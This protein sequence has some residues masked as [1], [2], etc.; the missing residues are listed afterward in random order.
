MPIPYRT[1]IDLLLIGGVNAMF[2]ILK[3]LMNKKVKNKD[4]NFIS[5]ESI[6]M[7]KKIRKLQLEKQKIDDK[8]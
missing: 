3:N 2:N 4:I 6:E 7:S 8:V 1:N 5:K